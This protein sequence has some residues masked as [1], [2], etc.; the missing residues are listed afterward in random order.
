MNYLFAPIETT[1]RDFQWKLNAYLDSNSSKVLV[2]GQADIINRLLFF[3]S[4]I[5]YLGKNIIQHGNQASSLLTSKLLRILSKK[6]SKLIFI[7]EEGGLFNLNADFAESVSIARHPIDLLPPNSVVCL[8]GNKQEK[9]IKS[10]YFSNSSIPS[11]LKLLTSGHPR[12][13]PLTPYT[14]NKIFSQMN[15]RFGKYILFNTNFSLLTSNDLG[16]LFSSS[17]G[18][19]KEVSSLNHYLSIYN[20]E[21]HALSLFL[22]CL[23]YACDNVDNDVS[24]YLKVHPGENPN[25]YKFIASHF[26]SVKLIQQTFI[27]IQYWILGSL[28][29]VSSRCTT[30]LEATALDHPHIS[31]CADR[32]LELESDTPLLQPSYSDTASLQTFSQKHHSFINLS[33]ESRNNYISKFSED[34]AFIASSHLEL[35]LFDRLHGTQLAA[36]AYNELLIEM[37]SSCT[38]SSPLIYTLA[39][40]FFTTLFYALKFNLDKYLRDKFSIAKKGFLK[41]VP[42]SNS[43]FLFLSSSHQTSNTLVDKFFMINFFSMVQLIIPKSSVSLLTS[44]LL[45]VFIRLFPFVSLLD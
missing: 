14:K 1:S 20:Y 15:N 31:L 2:V 3:V 44:K 21:S 34:F 32:L 43:E 19:R 11:S 16:K 41:F 28:Y 23:E 33:L 45:C 13:R 35:N 25:V 36:N 42:L 30:A 22:S 40:V 17:I 7:D 37:D 4:N 29:S 6:E 24:I 26:P 5:T 39:V 18:W 12:L 9:I 38:S 8:W 27:P 10:Y